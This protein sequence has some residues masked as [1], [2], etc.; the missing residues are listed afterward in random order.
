VYLERLRAISE[1]RRAAYATAR[2]P[3]YA[4]QP[5]QPTQTERQPERPAEQPIVPQITDMLKQIQE[6][7]KAVLQEEKTE[8]LQNTTQIYAHNK[9]REITDMIMELIELTDFYLKDQYLK[10]QFLKDQ[11]L[12]NPS[13]TKPTDQYEMIIKK[14]TVIVHFIYNLNQLPQLRRVYQC[15]EIIHAL[16][17]ISETPDNA[18]VLYERVKKLTV[19]IQYMAYFTRVITQMQNIAP[20]VIFIRSGQLQAIIR[21]L[22]I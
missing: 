8:P 17:Y 4:I 2:N 3:Q 15:G 18:A 13:L 21:A 22:T 20:Q 10:D 12:K 9:M 1:A 11:F 6:C 7:H 16:Y 5:S 19:I 14:L